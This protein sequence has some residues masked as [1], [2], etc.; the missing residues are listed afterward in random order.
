MNS[1]P[2]IVPYFLTGRF[3]FHH[4]RPLKLKYK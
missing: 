3:T 1:V 4:D 2:I